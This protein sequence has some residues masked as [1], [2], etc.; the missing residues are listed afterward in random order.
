MLMMYITTAPNAEM[1]I[2]LSVVPVYN[3]SK[4][5]APPATNAQCGV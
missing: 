4:P 2:T 3:E 1:M 5:T